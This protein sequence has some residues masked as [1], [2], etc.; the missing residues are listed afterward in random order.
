M[1]RR[2]TKC[3][4]IRSKHRHV[5]S[6]PVPSQHSRTGH[7]RTWPF[8][9]THTPLRALAARTSSARTEARQ[10][11]VPGAGQVAPY[12]TSG[13]S[14][15]AQGSRLSPSNAGFSPAVLG[16]ASASCALSSSHLPCSASTRLLLDYLSQPRTA[17]SRQVWWSGREPLSNLDGGIPL[18]RNT[19]AGWLFVRAPAR[20]SFFGG[21]GD[22]VVKA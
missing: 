18:F 4:P 21:G 20:F 10:P 15:C 7:V 19:N 2:H 1:S 14:R 9:F 13:P 22:P 8:V 17:P 11:L 12:V 16:S 5:T 6:S 3:N